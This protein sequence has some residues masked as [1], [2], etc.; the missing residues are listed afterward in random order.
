MLH[1]VTVKGVVSAALPSLQATCCCD[2]FS[3]HCTSL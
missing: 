1:F 3:G 2:Q